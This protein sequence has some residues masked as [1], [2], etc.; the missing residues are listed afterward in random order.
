MSL[1]FPK[2]VLKVYQDH[3]QPEYIHEQNRLQ[4]MAA[5]ILKPPV[6][7]AKKSV[8]TSSTQILE[9]QDAVKKIQV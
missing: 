3:K 1:Y 2:P 4:L 8:V 6:S 7:I 5:G 9:H